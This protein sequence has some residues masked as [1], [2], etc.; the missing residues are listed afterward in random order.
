M[1]HLHQDYNFEF[2]TRELAELYPFRI[3]AKDNNNNF[4]QKTLFGA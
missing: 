3:W 2:K 4:F 1:Q